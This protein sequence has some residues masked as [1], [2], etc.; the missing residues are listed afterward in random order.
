MQAS[1]GK[2]QGDKDL[3]GQNTWKEELSLCIEIEETPL[4]QHMHTVGLTGYLRPPLG[5]AKTGLKQQVVCEI[6]VG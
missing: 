5:V 3:H 4:T 6:R 2:A 1:Y